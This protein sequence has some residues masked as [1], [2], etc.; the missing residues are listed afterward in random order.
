MT[1]ADV[2]TDSE[3]KGNSEAD[4]VDIDLTAVFEVASS[5]DPKRDKI[6]DLLFR[7]LRPRR[8]DEEREPAIV[9]EII[10]SEC[11]NQLKE[12]EYLQQ[13]RSIKYNLSD[14][15]N[16]NF[17]SKVLL[18]YFQDTSFPKLKADDMASA[19]KNEERE[20]T[21]KRTLEECQSDW[22]TRHGA[23]Q[24]SGMFQC[25]KCK[26]TRTTYF[27]MQT[28]SAD[29]PMTTFVTCLNC[30]NKWKFC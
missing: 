26:G 29:E 13:I 7:S 4:D 3:A 6:R 14:A 28:R 5:G 8:L 27:Q 9:A 23:I 22:G 12:K 18:G 30:K 1:K 11:F 16:P 15:K 20:A 24:E 2:I 25:G 21:R 17:K 19:A 10:E